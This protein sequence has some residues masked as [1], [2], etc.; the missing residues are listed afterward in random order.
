MALVGLVEIG[1]HLSKAT[2]D[3]APGVLDVASNVVER[4]R[5]WSYANAL[6]LGAGNAIDIETAVDVLPGRL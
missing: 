1:G 4:E 6:I 5:Y 3:V 2:Q